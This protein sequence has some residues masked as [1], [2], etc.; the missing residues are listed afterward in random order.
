MQRIF[1]L[2][3]LKA[4]L[5]MSEALKY[6]EENLHDLDICQNIIHDVNSQLARTDFDKKLQDAKNDVL[7]TTDD[8]R[9]RDVDEMTAS[10]T[11]RK[12]ATLRINAPNS[13][14]RSSKSNSRTSKALISKSI[15]ETI[16]KSS[17]I[18]PTHRITTEARHGSN[19]P[20]QPVTGVMVQR[21]TI[22]PTSSSTDTLPDSYYEGRQL[23]FKMSYCNGSSASSAAHGLQMKLPLQR[24]DLLWL[25]DQFLQADFPQ[26]GTLS[27][28]DPSVFH[29]ADSVWPRISRFCKQSVFSLHPHADYLHTVARRASEG[30]YTTM[31]AVVSLHAA[32]KVLRTSVQKLSFVMLVNVT[33]REQRRYTT[34]IINA[35]CTD[36]LRQN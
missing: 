23:M 31:Q 25:L 6:S 18:A 26:G 12:S 34:F 9:W 10:K 29:S 17:T 1:N 33:S 7:Q 24:G 3:I 21:L 28:A 36:G 22:V 5:A 32:L 8:L 14:Q 30:T 35:S 2:T 16:D 15:S 27:C 4:W 20:D 19:T 11:L 13:T